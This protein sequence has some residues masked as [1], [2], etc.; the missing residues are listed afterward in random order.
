ME[1]SQ[2]VA[3]VLSWETLHFGQSLPS[4]FMKKA[5][6]FS[7]LAALSF[8]AGAPFGLGQPS[9][10]DP[11]FRPGTGAGGSSPNVYALAEQGNGKLLIVG[12]F[13]SFNGVPR[14]QVARLNADG[15]LDTG[16]DPGEGPGAG[17]SIGCVAVQP[18]GKVWIGGSFGAVNGNTRRSVARL[19]ED[20]SLDLS[21]AVDTDWAAVGSVLV[22]PDGKVLVGGRVTGAAAAKIVRLT[23]GG[24]LDD[25]FN[26]A[27]IASNQDP[28]SAGFL[29][30]IPQIGSG[31]FLVGRFDSVNGTNR[32]SVARL[33][34]DGSLDL[35]FNPDP[36]NGA[37]SRAAIQPDG[38]VVVAGSFSSINGYTRYGIGR[39]NSDGTLDTSFKPGLVQYAVT[40]LALQ[41]DGK[42][43]VGQRE[44][45]FGGITRLNDDGSQDVSFSCGSSTDNDVATLLVQ[46]DGR[47]LA[48]GWFRTFDGKPSGGIVR[49]NALYLSM[50]NL[51]ANGGCQLRVWTQS[52]RHLALQASANLLSWTSLSDF[53]AT[54]DVVSLIDAESP[55]YSARFYRVIQ[56]P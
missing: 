53:I 42:V 43:L 50:P 27:T 12:P 51:L 30:I 55:K 3:V 10:L 49:L 32:N 45:N 5:G 6:F 39:L 23:A 54:N 7:S 15:S 11:T 35:A 8:L 2:N 31:I 48:G 14:H 4:I 29:P 17:G 38:K 18:D 21:L 33:R 40:S 22:L 13:T 25:S 1:I 36:M 20:G 44:G 28:W 34:N 46:A 24:Q 19:R 9:L 41:P 52:G 26:Q 47:V 37:V 16:F 56:L